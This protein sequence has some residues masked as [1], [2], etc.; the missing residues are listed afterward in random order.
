MAD[1]KFDMNESIDVAV[2]VT[3]VYYSHPAA[4]RDLEEWEY[5]MRKNI[6][7][8]FGF[9]SGTKRTYLMIHGDGV[10]EVVVCLPIDLAGE[11]VAT[12]RL[13]IQDACDLAVKCLR[14]TYS[15]SIIFGFEYW[16]NIII[17]NIDCVGLQGVHKI[18]NNLENSDLDMCKQRV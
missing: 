1:P 11:G 13:A 8:K 5:F 15:E 6:V 7:M 16:K 10:Y 14:P 2:K 4:V 17:G 3:M 12:N 18:V 9:P